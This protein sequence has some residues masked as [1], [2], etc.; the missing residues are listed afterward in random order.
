MAAPRKKVTR[1]GI[2]QKFP[3]IFRTF[4]TCSAC[5]RRRERGERLWDSKNV[6]VAR[7]KC[8]WCV[9]SVAKLRDSTAVHSNRRGVSFFAREI[10]RSICSTMF[11]ANAKSVL[12]STFAWNKY[13]LDRNSE[14]PSK[15]KHFKAGTFKKNFQNSSKTK[16]E[17]E[18]EKFRDIKVLQI[19]DENENLLLWWSITWNIQ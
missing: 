18:R 13:T 8:H 15:V 1:L 19:R 12:E 17:R 4:G 3:R 6:S 9:S 16:R 14:I 7:G 11:R 5:T 2:L 10:N